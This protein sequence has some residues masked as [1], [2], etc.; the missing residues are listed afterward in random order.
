MYKE[1]PFTIKETTINT[2]IIIK[3]IRREASREQEQTE[4][5]VSVEMNELFPE[6]IKDTIYKLCKKL[7]EEFNIS[8]V[9][10]ELVKNG[11]K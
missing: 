9:E 10:A 6:L 3:T 7:K 11:N 2:G 4:N 1:P 5:L 8:Q